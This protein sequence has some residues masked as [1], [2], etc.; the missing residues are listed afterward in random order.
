MN[1]YEFKAW[2]EGFSEGVN[3]EPT[4]TQWNKIRNKIKYLNEPIA[5]SNAKDPKYYG[6][7]WADQAGATIP[8]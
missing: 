4:L 1:V 2:F 6:R 7:R 8:A 5:L 3:G